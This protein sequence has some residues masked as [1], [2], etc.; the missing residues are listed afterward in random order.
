V[1]TRL[2]SVFLCSTRWPRR[3]RSDPNHLPGARICRRSRSTNSL[4]TTFCRSTRVSFANAGAG[5]AS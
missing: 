4:A 5:G 1:R 2:R 3:S